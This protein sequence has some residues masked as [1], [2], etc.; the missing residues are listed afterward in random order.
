MNLNMKTHRRNYITNLTV[1]LVLLIHLWCWQC[2]APV[3]YINRSCPPGFSMHCY[4]L[5][6]PFGSNAVSSLTIS[7]VG[8]NGISILTAGTNGF[9]ANNYLEGW[10]D[11]S[12]LLPLGHGWFFKNPYGSNLTTTIAGDI[13]QGNN[14]FTIPQGF[15]VAGSANFVG[16]GLTSGLFFPASN[17]D[18]VYIYNVTNGTYSNYVFSGSWSPVEPVLEN[19]Q[20]FWVHKQVSS[21]WCTTF[22]NEV[23]VGLGPQSF[24]TNRIGPSLVTSQVGQLNFFT[25]NATNAGLG[26]VYGIDGITPLSGTYVAQLYAR[27][28]SVANMLQPIGVPVGFMNGNAAGYVR[29][30]TVFVPFATGDQTVWVQLRVWNL[31][32]GATYE[33][34]I[35]NGSLVGKSQVM[36]LTARATIE[37]G[38]PGIPPPDVNT[39]SSLILEQLP[40]ITVQPQSQTNAVGTSVS[41]NVVVSGS[42]PLSCQWR[43]NGVNISGA[44][45]TN[46]TIANVQVTNAGAY[47][48]VASNA[49][50]SVT[51][52]VAILTVPDIVIAQWNFNSAPPDGNDSTGAILPSYGVGT[53]STAG[54]VSTAFNTGHTASDPAGSSDNSSW[55]LSNFPS[56]TQSNKSAGA[57]FDVSTAGRQNIRVSWW[58]RPSS[59]ASRYVRL[60][61]STNGGANFFD[62]PSAHQMSGTSFQSMS[63][64]LSSIAGLNNQSGFVCRIVTEFENTA[65]GS[66]MARYIGVSGG[67]GSYAPGGDISFD[68]V[69]VYG[70]VMNLPFSVGSPGFISG[71]VFQFGVTGQLGANY[72]I[73]GTTNL[74]PANWIPLQT[75]V[76][77]FT[78]YD[79][80]AVD[81]PQRFYRLISPLQ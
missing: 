35:T 9:V 63:N 79:S 64:N 69:T 42:A 20:S 66:G 31:A 58:Q 17:G 41:F 36:S 73:Q 18:M 8:T 11:P 46:Y 56:S 3:G 26:R 28:N 62:A 1:G 30:G 33:Q 72:V 57:R 51:S 21:N 6:G 54:G 65:T 71:G 19:G 37:S 14:S 44:T 53:A 77:P 80:N 34:A 10:A 49:A 55:R 22:T 61:Y 40:V 15:S 24:P 2:F 45:A 52:A 29:S 50:G 68:M 13:L 75:N 4:P 38:L 67:G 32:L 59:N 47:S 7:G 48:V 39:F 27:T 43:F 12:A 81:F 70:D 78:F 16:S 23:G 76:S 74:S 5:V 25:Y 60:Q